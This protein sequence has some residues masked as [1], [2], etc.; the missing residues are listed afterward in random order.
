MPTQ[1]V[2]LTDRHRQA[3][4]EVLDTFAGRRFRRSDVADRIYPLTTPR[5]RERA[6]SICDQLLREAGSIG[7]IRR[8]GHLHWIS[9]TRSRA[10]VDGTTVPELDQVHQ[11]SL[12]TRCPDKWLAVDLETGQVWRGSVNGWKRHVG[13]DRNAM[14]R[15]VGTKTPKAAKQT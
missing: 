4:A 14:A 7:R 1:Q 5:S 6:N 8:E 11:L 2:K 13:P 10:L 9:V 15:L 12:E 3:L